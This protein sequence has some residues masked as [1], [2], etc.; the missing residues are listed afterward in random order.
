MVPHIFAHSLQHSLEILGILAFAMSG[1]LLAVRKGFD[2]VGMLVLAEVTALGGGIFRD[3]IIG[4]TPPAAFT[5]FG[6]GL[7]PVVGT[8]IVF[9]LH[10]EVER[11]NSAVMGVDAVGLGLFCVSGTIKAHAYGLGLLAS[12]ALGVA[13]AVGGG[14]LRD[15]F[16]REVPML[17]RWDQDL[18]SVPAM[19]G[20][21][22]VVV[23]IHYHHLNGVTSALAAFTACVL[24]LLSMRFHWRAPRA[25][26][27]KAADS[28]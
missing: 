15:V 22:I 16:A 7:T 17:L 6:Y 8:A 28:T 25:W 2:V 12:A 10:P 9:F 5:D 24:R 19:V 3:L 18:Y 13:T 23:L 26:N 1:A 20:S 11:I 4:A 14:V 27:R 21:A